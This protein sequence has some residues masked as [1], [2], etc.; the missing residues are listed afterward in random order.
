MKPSDIVLTPIAQ[1][2][3]K[4]KKRPAIVLCQ[5]PPFQ[6]FLV[7]GLSTQFHQQAKNF[8]EIISSSD[9]DFANSN[10]KMDSLIR[11]GFL[12]IVS[13]G[14]IVGVIGSI[15]PERHQRLLK[16]LGQYFLDLVA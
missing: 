11:L 8:D 12:G 6:D 9:E 15:S 2:D 1:T 16:R 4:V 5:L 3:G 13:R 10:L 7:C 14:E